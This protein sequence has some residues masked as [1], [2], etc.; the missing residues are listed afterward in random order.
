MSGYLVL[1]SAEERISSLN[2]N[3]PA[4]PLDRIPDDGAVLSKN[5]GSKPCSPQCSVVKVQADEV[6]V[7]HLCPSLAMAVL[8]QLP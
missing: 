1:Q 8:P 4:L 2:L 3:L 5:V 6:D 7:C